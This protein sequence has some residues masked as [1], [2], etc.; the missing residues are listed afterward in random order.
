MEAADKGLQGGASLHMDHHLD[1][2]EGDSVDAAQGN[3]FQETQRQPVDPHATPATQ[4]LE[5]EGQQ[6]TAL[7]P[8]GLQGQV[9]A[10][11]AREM[12]LEMGV[13]APPHQK[14]AG[15]MLQPLWDRGEDSG[16]LGGMVQA[17]PQDRE[18]SFHGQEPYLR[19]HIW[20]CHFAVSSPEE[21]G[22][23]LGTS[24]SG[25]YGWGSGL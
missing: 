14:R 24:G 22:P 3:L 13:Q 4:G 9:S 11:Q 6:S 5:A 2:C 25:S 18:G 16:P 20:L 17:H 21:V 15:V 1:A 12:Q 8:V 19:G 7:L 23:N 10:G